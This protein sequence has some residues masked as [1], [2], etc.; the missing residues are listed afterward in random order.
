MSIDPQS[1]QGTATPLLAIAHQF[2]D[3]EVPW[4]VVPFG[5]GLINTTWKV[6]APQVA[7]SYILQQINCTVFTEPLQIAHNTQRISAFLRQAYPNYLFVLPMLTHEGTPMLQADKHGWYRMLPFVQG[8]HTIDTVSTPDQAYQA[9]LQ[10]GRFTE[11]LHHFPIDTLHIT[12]PHFHNLSL[13]HYLFMRALHTA[14]AHLVEAARTEMDFLQAQ[15][16]IVERYEA[17]VNGGTVP[18]RVIHH[19]TKISNTLFDEAQQGMCVID[20]D[21]VMPGYFISDVGDM[22]RTY[23]CP[24]SE[25][26]TQLDAIDIRLPYFEAMAKGYL[27]AMGPVLTPQEWAHFTYAGPFIIYMQALRFAT[28]YLQGNVYYPVAHPLHNLHRTQNQIALLQA[29]Q[30]HMPALEAIVQRLRQQYRA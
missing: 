14:P 26:S 8:S 21:T 9:A 16:A 19:D 6:T 15:Q 17:M 29:Y 2:L 23:L 28:D 24:H 13:R 30:R 1:S 20:L 12:L 27:E 18:L 25:E 3:P 7:E 4:Q 10:F 22:C 5:S 11:H